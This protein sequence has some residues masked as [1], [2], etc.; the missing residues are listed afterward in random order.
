MQRSIKEGQRY[1]R[2]VVQC[3]SRKEK[4]NTYVSCKWLCLCDCGKERE[5]EGKSLLAGLTQ[6]CGCLHKEAIANVNKG[7]QICPNLIGMRFGRLLVTARENNDR[8]RKSRWR[9]LCTCGKETIT[10]GQSLISGRST[11]CG[12]YHKEKVTTHG[13]SKTPSYRSVAQ[14]CRREMESLLDSEWTVAH[15]ECLRSFFSFCVICGSDKDLTTDHVH[16]LS[17]GYGL[18]PGNVIRL[19]KRCNCIKW[20]KNL[21]SLPVEWEDTIKVK[22]HEFLLY[23]NNLNEIA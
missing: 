11:S 9:C 8:K 4:R 20:A 14:I 10:T 1:G 12:C 22:A 7:K 3:F 2:L 17:K 23:W 5:I 19:C 15:E 6:S 18:K 21:D 13:L 16:P